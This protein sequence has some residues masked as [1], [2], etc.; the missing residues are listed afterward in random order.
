MSWSECC[1]RVIAFSAACQRYMM[2]TTAVAVVAQT[3]YFVG[4]SYC[5]RKPMKCNDYF[6]M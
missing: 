6:L 5:N 1:G 2:D 4:A 3:S